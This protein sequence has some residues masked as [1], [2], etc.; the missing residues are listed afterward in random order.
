MKAIKLDQLKKVVGE[1][2]TNARRAAKAAESGSQTHQ[3]YWNGVKVGYYVSALNLC[4]TAHLDIEATQE[5]CGKEMPG[6]VEGV[7]Q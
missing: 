2:M 1:L 4:V 3:A 6:L 7:A 5:L